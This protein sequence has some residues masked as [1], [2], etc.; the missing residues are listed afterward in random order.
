MPK[1]IPLNLLASFALV[2]LLHF[3]AVAQLSPLS[4][5]HETDAQNQITL[6]LNGNLSANFLCAGAGCSGWTV[7]IGGVNQTPTSVVGANGT[8][9]VTISFTTPV[10]INAGTGKG[11]VVTVTFTGGGG[12]DAFAGFASVNQHQIICSDFSFTGYFDASLKCAPVEPESQMIFAVKPVAR[13]SQF[14]SLTFTTGRVSWI[15]AGV[16]PFSVLASEETNSG[17]SATANTY[18]VGFH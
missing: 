13:N 17:G 9:S 3:A 2:L 1:R 7:T 14:W 10:G 18:F 15:T 4:A 11:E 8:N 5:T 12:I 6:R 16:A